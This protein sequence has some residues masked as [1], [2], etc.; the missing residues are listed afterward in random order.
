MKNVGK[1]DF[2]V[3]IGCHAFN[4]CCLKEVSMDQLA[5]K[6]SQCCTYRL[7]ANV[8]HEEQ[9]VLGGLCFGGSSIILGASLSNG[10]PVILL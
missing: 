3:R 4:R 2:A 10:C 1:T 7:Q 6:E 9:G 8:V 5:G